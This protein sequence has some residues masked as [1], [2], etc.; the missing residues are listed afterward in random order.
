VLDDL[1]PI[2][3]ELLNGDF[4]A[5]YLAWCVLSA[6]LRS[7]KKMKKLKKMLDTIFT[8]KTDSQKQLE[9]PPYFTMQ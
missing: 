7:K 1:I 6:K 5:L 8:N 4:R 2:R 3:H 9:Q